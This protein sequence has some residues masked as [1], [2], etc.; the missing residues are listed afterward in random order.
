MRVTHQY[1]V[2]FGNGTKLLINMQC[3]CVNMRSIDKG[4]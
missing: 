3:Q 1:A 2:S 4:E